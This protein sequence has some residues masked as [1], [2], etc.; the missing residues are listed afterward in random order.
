MGSPV[1]WLW[2]ASESPCASLL[3]DGDVPVLAVGRVKL[4][5]LLHVHVEVLLLRLGR[6]M[7]LAGPALG[8][9]LRL[10][11]GRVLHPDVYA[12]PVKSWQA[13][14]DH[15]HPRE[16]SQHLEMCHASYGSVFQKRARLPELC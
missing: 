1:E 14:A 13:L 11:L 3:S 15:K 4:L 6:N 16:R 12:K 7:A 5:A 2:W 10:S 8:R 9:R